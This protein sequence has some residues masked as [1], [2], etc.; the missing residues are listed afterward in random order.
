MI[1]K[2]TIGIWVNM[3]I[4]VCPL[5]GGTSTTGDL[6]KVDRLITSG[7]HEQALVEVRL[8]RRALPSS[9]RLA[10]WELDFRGEVLR[11][12]HGRECLYY[13]LHLA[14]SHKDAPGRRSARA[15]GRRRP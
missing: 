6:D 9:E 13:L 3:V 8:L 7:K 2:I 12:A 10:A 1:W 15:S 11:V 4:C 14:N 5:L